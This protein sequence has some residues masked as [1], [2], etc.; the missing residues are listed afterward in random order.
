M[1]SLE[2][3]SWQGIEKLGGPAAK[4]IGCLHKGGVSS[5]YAPATRDKSSQ[6]ACGEVSLPAAGGCDWG[7]PLSVS[8][9]SSLI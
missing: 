8:H 7:L 9:F 3:S 6:A 5:R 1:K 4:S 2:S